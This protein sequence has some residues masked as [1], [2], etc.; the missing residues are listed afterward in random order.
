ME[1]KSC[2]SVESTLDRG[3]ATSP[4]YVGGS[5]SLENLI[6][7]AKVGPWCVA[8]WDNCVRSPP[9]TSPSGGGRSESS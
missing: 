7:E 6:K 5:K 3:T 4:L 2:Y 9:A 8:Q 1:R